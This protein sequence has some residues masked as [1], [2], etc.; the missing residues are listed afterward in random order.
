[1]AGSISCAPVRGFT[2]NGE[3]VTA[4]AAVVTAA[5]VGVR[6]VSC[7]AVVTIGV[8][9]V[10]AAAFEHPVIRIDAPKRTETANINPAR[11]NLVEDLLFILISLLV[12]FVDFDF[13]INEN[14]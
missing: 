6:D 14:K 4:G 8:V 11:I 1:M 12:R 2:A 7:A 5:A 3:S 9:S 13:T 10:T